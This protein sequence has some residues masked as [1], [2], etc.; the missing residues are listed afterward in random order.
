MHM[1]DHKALRRM[2]LELL[3]QSFHED[4]LRMVEPDVFF[5]APPLDRTNIVPNMHYLSDRKLVEMMMG[6]AP[7]MFSAVRITPAGIDLVENRFNFNLQFPPA[8]HDSESVI[9][10]LLE[11]LVEEGDFLPLDG[12]ARRQLLGDILYLREELNRPAD[13]WR[14]GIVTSVLDAIATHR[15]RAEC[16]LETLEQL[17]TAVNAVIVS[18]D[19]A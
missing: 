1:E 11:Q 2:I 7:P 15:T 6:Y 5:A 19:Q 16:P 18:R 14:H 12:L 10:A 8:R 3:Y 17:R 13:R 9:P 4:P